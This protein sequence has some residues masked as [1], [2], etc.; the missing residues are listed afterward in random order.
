MQSQT[1][2]VRFFLPDDTFG[3]S[4]SDALKTAPIPDL[5]GWRMSLAVLEEATHR[6]S[7]DPSLGPP[8]HGDFSFPVRKQ[9]FN[10][11]IGAQF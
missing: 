11:A 3:L 2:F 7:M 4:S 10:I 6:E 5:T 9:V 8:I 1:A